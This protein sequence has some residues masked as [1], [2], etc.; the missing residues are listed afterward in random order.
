MPRLLEPKN[1]PLPSDIRELTSVRFFAAIWVVILHFGFELPVPLAEVS[2]VFERGDLGVDLFFILS[3]FILTHVYLD[4][5]ADGRFSYPRYILYRL[6]RVY[7]LHLVTLAA[8][9]AVI[10][11]AQAMGV[12]AE[13]PVPWGDLPAHLLM[14][15]AWGTTG[16]TAFNDPSWS[17][18]AEWFAYLATPVF[19]FIAVRL[20]RWPIAFVAAGVALVLAAD[21]FARYVIGRPLTLLILDYAVLRIAVEFLLGC[22]LYKLSAAVTCTRWVATAMAVACA[23]AALAL[24]HFGVDAIVVVLLHG[25]L[26]FALSQMSKHSAGNPMRWN[27]LVYLGEISYAIYMCHALVDRVYFFEAKNLLGYPS[28]LPLPYWLPAFIVL[29]AAAAIAHHWIELP[30][31]VLVRRCTDRWFPKR[32]PI[33]T[34]IVH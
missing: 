22:A 15:H 6:G 4:G 12:A 31:R 14:I 17:I 3:G 1:R 8:A 25:G 19:F 26:V 18:S 23:V 29:F 20:G 27:A 2:P 33:S 28:G 30:G 9:I 11:L 21:Q 10:V 24:L 13:G 7:P 32:D 34:Q 5:F 16:Q